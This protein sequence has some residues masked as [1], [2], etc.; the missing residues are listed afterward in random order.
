MGGFSVWSKERE[1]LQG[2]NLPMSIVFFNAIEE[3]NQLKELDK[4]IVWKCPDCMHSEVR[5][6]DWITA[7]KAALEWVRKQPSDWGEKNR[8]WS[9]G[10]TDKEVATK[11]LEHMISTLEHAGKTVQIEDECTMC[12]HPRC[13]EVQVTTKG[14]VIKPYGTEMDPEKFDEL[15]HKQMKGGLGIAYVE[16]KEVAN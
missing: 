8:S 13:K 3:A 11:T 10:A 9:S 14:K 7:C 16:H 1:W 15:I 4:S 2:L 12:L 6:S 5:V